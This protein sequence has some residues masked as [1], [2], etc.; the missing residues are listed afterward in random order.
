MVLVPCTLK[1]GN[2]WNF[3]A[4]FTSFQFHLCEEKE[5]AKTLVQL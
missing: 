4:S 1:S 3:Q 2:Q 5:N